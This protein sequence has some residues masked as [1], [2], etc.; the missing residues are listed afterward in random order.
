MSSFANPHYMYLF[1]LKNGK[2]KLAYGQSPED[3]LEILSIRLS[4]EEMDQIL[5]DSFTENHLAILQQLADGST[6]KSHRDIEGQ[7]VYRIHRLDGT[8]ETPNAK[9]VDQLKNGRYIDSN[10]KFPAATYMLTDK[11]RQAIVAVTRVKISALSTR[12]YIR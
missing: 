7:K 5:S 8:A 1:D 9:A 12:N 10:K 3:A 6:L 4:Q 11:G 2:K